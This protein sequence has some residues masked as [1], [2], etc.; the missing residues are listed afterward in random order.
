[1]LRT[2]L[3]LAFILAVAGCGNG[4]H[5][6]ADMKPSSPDMAPAHTLLGTLNDLAAFGQKRV[7]TDANHQAQAYLVK[8]FQDA[9]LANVHVESFQF[10]R[11]DVMSSSMTLSVSGA[12]VSPS[13]GFDVFESSGSGHADGPVVYVGFATPSD[14]T[15]VDLTGKIALVDRSNSLHRAV[16]YKNVHQAGA[17]AMLY[18]SAAVNNLRQVGSVRYKFEGM[19][20]IPAITIGKDDGDMLKAAIMAGKNV[21]AV[22]DVQAVNTPAVGGNVTGMIAGSDPTGEV[23]IGGHYDSWFAGSTD[24]GAGAAAVVALA[25]AYVKRKARPRYTIIFNAYDGEEVALYGGY[26]FLRNHHITSSEPILA[27]VNLEIPAVANTDQKAM[28]WSA[29]QALGDTLSSAGF[30]AQ[31]TTF[32]DMEFVPN[33]YG[34]II[35]TDIQGIY[36]NGIP[37]VTTACDSSYYH[38]TDDTPDKV[39]VAFLGATVTNLESFLDKMML[40]DPSAFATV[41]SELYQATIEQNFRASTD[42]LNIDVTIKD[43][44]GKPVAGTPVNVTLVYDDFFDAQDPTDTMSDASG[45]VHV[46]VPPAVANQGKGNRWVHVTAGPVW[47]LV[48]QLIPILPAP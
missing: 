3:G 46:S 41:D 38:T 45:K 8:R 26:T 36:R 15:G 34:G 29:H 17:T 18:L 11:H 35:P 23:V 37:T 48:E 33:V 42:P 19:G 12:P 40:E 7:G 13:V 24:N 27:V 2:S 25:E 22:I 4:S 32:V 1:M 43:S 6:T 47:P 9:G 5:S 21:A 39:D 14:L 44:T 30:A 16:Q 31:Y 28:A 20:P 10:P